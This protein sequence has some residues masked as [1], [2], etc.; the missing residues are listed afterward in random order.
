MPRYT[1]F[2]VVLYRG[3][4]GLIIPTDKQERVIPR[5]GKKQT[6]RTRISI[7]I[8]ARAGLLASYI[9]RRR[10]SRL[11]S[12]TLIQP[13]PTSLGAFPLDFVPPPSPHTH[14]GSYCWTSE[15]LLN[16]RNKRNGKRGTGLHFLP[17]PRAG[18]VLGH[19]SSVTKRD[20]RRKM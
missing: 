12:L 20:K 7:P 2:A 10:R 5:T 13:G 3:A 6:G 11:V 17:P 15:D 8:P 14:P 18:Y 19:C 1:G 16:S 4:R 9:A